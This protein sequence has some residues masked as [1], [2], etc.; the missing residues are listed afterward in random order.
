MKLKKEILDMIK[1]PLSCNRIGSDLQVAGSSV[2]VQVRANNEN[3]RLTKMDALLAI[4]KETGVPVDQLC[5]V[6]SEMVPQN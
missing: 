6:S 1:N 2:S 3:G 4:S 5:E